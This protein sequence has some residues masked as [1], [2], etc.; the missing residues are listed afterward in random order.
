MGVVGVAQELHLN[1]VA[2]QQTLAA[3]QQ[4]RDDE[5]GHRRDEHHGDTGENARQRQWKDHPAEYLGVAGPQVLGCLDDPVVDLLDDG[6]NGQDHKGQEVIHHAQHHRSGG[7][8]DVQLG[9]A[10][11][12]EQR[13]EKAVAFQQKHPGIGPQQEVHPHGQH[14]QHGGHPPQPAPL[15]GQKVGHGVTQQNADNRGNARQ[16]EGSGKNC[17]VTHHAGEVLQRAVPT[18]I[19]Q[20]PGEGVH[21]HHDQRRNHEQS[22]PP[23]VGVGH[24]LI[25]HSRPPGALPPAPPPGPEPPRRRVRRTPHCTSCNRR[26]CRSTG[27]SS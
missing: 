23:H 13:V 26:T 1:E 4:A 15:P 9:Q 22:H 3:A 8:D 5:G 16:Q 21:Q 18:A 25:P 11:G 17:G 24:V 10:D 27:S 19:R 14:D 2:Q 20:F 7:V 6:E 12:A